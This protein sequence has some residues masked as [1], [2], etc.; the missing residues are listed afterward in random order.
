MHVVD[1]WGLRG[2]VEYSAL[3]SI[4]AMLGGWSPIHTHHSEKWTQIWCTSEWQS[5]TLI[6][7]TV[8][9][10]TYT[11]KNWSTGTSA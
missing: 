3:W 7:E 11:D 5:I 1:S 2:A 9:R 4:E 10:E 6:T 8:R